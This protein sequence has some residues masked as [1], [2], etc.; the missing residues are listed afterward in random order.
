MTQPPVRYENYP[1][2]PDETREGPPG[3]GGPYP[4]VRPYL[5]ATIPAPPRSGT[6]RRTVLALVI[7]IPVAGILLSAIASSGNSNDRAGASSDGSGN[8]WVGDQTISVGNYE[9]NAPE[10]WTM[11]DDL[12]GTVEV[13]NESNRLT[14]V[15][16]DTQANNPAVEEIARLAEGRYSG[17]SGKVGDPVDRSS[18]ELQHATMDGTGTYR[19]E[20]AR[21]LVELWIDNSGNGLLVARVMTAKPSSVISAEAQEMVDELSSDF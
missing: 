12:N 14:A 21:L 10:G 17:F 15:L 3:A 5:P 20:A 11:E 6:S 4:V 19:G 13:M 7:G 16:I 9:A 18:A 1:P 8:G 2:D